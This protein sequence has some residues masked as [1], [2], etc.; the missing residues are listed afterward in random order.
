MAFNLLKDRWILVVCTTFI[1]LNAVLM[2]FEQYWLNLLP[3]ALILGWAM[4]ARADRVLLFIVFATP[5]SINMEQLDLGGIGVA[6]PTEP[7]MVC[8]TLLFLLKLGLERGV[9]DARVWRHP[10]T[11]VIIAQLVWMAFC[12]IPS[13]LPMVSVKYLAA[14]LWFVC[15]MYFMATRLFERPANMQRF[16]WLYMAGLSIVI[17]YTLIRHVL[18]EVKRDKPLQCK[19]W[20][21]IAKVTPEELRPVLDELDG[22]DVD[23]IV[24][25]GTN[26][27][28]V[29]LA[30]EYETRLNK[31]VIAINTA[32]YWHGL[33]ACGI[34]DRIS[35]LGRLLAEF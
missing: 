31:P 4:I 7:L 26:L 1:L 13:S 32:T 20:T 22:D 33:R 27:S 16:A 8:L 11:V 5:L 23:A 15:T 6:I 17:G 28:M 10:I 19:R 29:D 18:F 2:A 21:D 9:L 34:H 25:V 35:G 12:I 24:Q 14:R 30:T 3:V